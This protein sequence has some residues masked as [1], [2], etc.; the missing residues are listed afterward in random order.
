MRAAGEHCISAGVNVPLIAAVAKETPP[1]AAPFLPLLKAESGVLTADL[2]KGLKAEGK[3]DF[4]GE[5]DAKAG[6]K[7]VNAALDLARG[8][9]VMGIQQIGKQKDMDRFVALLEEVQTGLRAAKV[10]RNGSSVEVTAAAKIDLQQAAPDLVE[11]VQKARNAATRMS[12]INNLKQLALAMYNYESTYNHFPAAAV[13]DKNG[14]PL[15]SWRILVL[16]YIE[17]DALYKEFHLDEPWDSDHNKKLLE[18]MPPLFAAGDE[19]ALKNHETHYQTFVGKGSIFDDKKGVKIQDVTDG[20]SNTIMIVEAKKAVPWTK[21]EDV[22]FDAGKLVPKLG[23]LF[24]GIFNVAFADGSVR[25]MPLTI[26]EEKLR[27]L[28]RA[29]APKSLIRANKKSCDPSAAL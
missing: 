1:Q 28:S 10:E 15:L 13:Y 9:L 6:E 4:A 21:P 24:E 26:K 7:A 8:G 11:A 23:G 2:G 19:Q 27:A 12:S 17:Q 22:P 5:S 14:K 25:S 29:T 18:K 16:P 3:L 20:T